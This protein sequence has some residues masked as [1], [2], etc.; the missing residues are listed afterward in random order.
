MVKQE[1]IGD[2]EANRWLRRS[3]RAPW[4]HPAAA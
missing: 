1:V 3:Y 4:T 2:A